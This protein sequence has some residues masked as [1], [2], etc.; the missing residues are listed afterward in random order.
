MQFER[1]HRAGRAV[2]LFIDVSAKQ[3]ADP[4]FL[5]V[6]APVIV[7]LRVAG[8]S[9]W[10]KLRAG[11]LQSAS[12]TTRAALQTLAAAGARIIVGGLGSGGVETTTLKGLRVEALAFDAALIGTDQA[13][14]AGTAK[15]RL[16]VR[17]GANMS[18]PVM[19]EGVI[20]ES[21]HA[22]ATQLGCTS[23]NGPLYGGP[24]LGDHLDF[25]GSGMSRR[26]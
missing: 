6:L 2:E 8:S 9:L 11:E 25:S 17:L 4:E 10:L 15:A 14:Q 3:L 19:V 20:D 24:T 12:D 22:I 1:W 21:Q 5:D 18:V 7:R 16:I 23:G 13:P 26:T